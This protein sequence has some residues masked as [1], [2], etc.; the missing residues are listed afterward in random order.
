MKVNVLEVHERPVELDFELPPQKIGLSAEE[1]IAF[2]APVRGRLK[3]FSVGEEIL[4]TG[5]LST[6]VRLTCV[7]CLRTFTA[8]LENPRIQ[9][10][11]APGLP[12]DEEDEEVEVGPDDEDVVHFEGSEILLDNELREC[13]LLELPA[14]PHCPGE[15]EIVTSGPDGRVA[16]EVEAEAADRPEWKNK[17]KNIRLDETKPEGGV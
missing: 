15:C 13:L 2:A 16:A 3:L 8:P 7:R 11:F 6:E 5:Q 4:A 9:L 17:L 12:R 14:H 10:R 1:G